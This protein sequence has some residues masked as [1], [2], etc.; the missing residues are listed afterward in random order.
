[1]IRKGQDHLLALVV[2]GGGN[3]SI[4]AGPDGATAPTLDGG[5]RGYDRTVIRGARFQVD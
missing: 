2:S 5:E 1:M 4:M 3:G